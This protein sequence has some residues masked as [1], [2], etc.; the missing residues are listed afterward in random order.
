M[1]V[2]ACIAL[3]ARELFL[4]ETLDPRSQKFNESQVRTIFTACT[5]AWREPAKLMSLK[6][7]CLPV[8][9]EAS[10]TL[11]KQSVVLA[12]PCRK[13]NPVSAGKRRIKTGQKDSSTVQ[14]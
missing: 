10:A 14:D 9:I 5:S 4:G 11:M 12:M 8:P 3:C 2:T 13:E 1:N 7:D 6:L